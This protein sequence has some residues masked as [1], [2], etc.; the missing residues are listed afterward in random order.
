MS[1][2]A[3]PDDGF[4]AFVEQHWAPLVRIA[5]LLTGDRGYAEDLVQAALE[6]THRKWGRVA[7]M[8]APVAYVRRAMVNTATS[9]R[10]R[11]RVGEVPLLTTDGPS[12][13]PYGSV[14]HR[15][16][17]VAALRTLPPRMRAVLVLRYFGDLTEA[18]IAET[19]GCSAGTVK[20]QAS[21]GLERLRE[22]I[23]PAAL[24]RTRG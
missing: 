23:T 14:E 12:T 9:W 13:D 20:S 4:R 5:Y 10:R 16:Q 11:R 6:K 1:S 8:E 22:L 15:Q 18:E 19:L 7:K 3:P 24:E 2:H 21:R 17:V